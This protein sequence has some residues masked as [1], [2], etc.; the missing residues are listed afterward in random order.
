MYI[1]QNR[2]TMAQVSNANI[3]EIVVRLLI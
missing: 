2:N 1:S 3:G